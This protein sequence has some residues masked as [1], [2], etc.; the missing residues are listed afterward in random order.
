MRGG[1]SIKGKKLG[2]GGNTGANESNHNH[3]SDSNSDS[4]SSSDKD[5]KSE[6]K[7][8]KKPWDTRKHSVKE[9]LK[10]LEEKVTLVRSLEMQLLNWKPSSRMSKKKVR[11]EFKWTGEETNFAETVNNYIRNQL[12]P[13]F[14][15][16]KD[17]WR[18]I[19][20][21]KRNSLYSLCMQHLKIPEGA[22]ARDIWLR[23]II[24]TISRKY[25]HMKGNL[26]N[27]IKS[28][29]MSTMTGYIMFSLCCSFESHTDIEFI[30]FA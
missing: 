6:R 20:P 22:D 11:E 17:G 5:S 14:K 3:N 9:L 15:F 7:S 27:D 23:V 18:E 8:R 1:K 19:Q 16:L 13:N 12:F 25:Q 30:Y 26:N 2:V 28:I 10:E 4:D 29:Y 21:D 24:P